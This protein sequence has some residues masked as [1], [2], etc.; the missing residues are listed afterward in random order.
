MENEHGKPKSDSVRRKRITGEIGHGGRPMSATAYDIGAETAILGGMM[1]SPT[2]IAACEDLNPTHFSQPH[3]LIFS[4]IAELHRTGKPILPRTVTTELRERGNL[5]AAGGAV[6]VSGLTYEGTTGA[7]SAAYFVGVVAAKWEH[8]RAREIA[9]HLHHDME[10][11]G[12]LASFDTAMDAVRKLKAQSSGSAPLAASLAARRFNAA[13]PPAQPRPIYTLADATIA[14]PGNIQAV[15]AQAKAGKTAFVG[16]MIAATMQPTGD[17]LGV[18]SSNPTAAAVV[19]FDTEQSPYDHHAVITQALGRAGCEAPDWLRSYRLA[20]VGIADRLGLLRFELAAAREKHGAIHSVFLDGV[21]DLCHDPNDSAEAFALVG[22]L[23]KL[24][25][26]F[27]TTIVCVLHENPGSETGKTRGH[28]GSQ[29][30]RKAE[31][32][33][34]LSKDGEAITTAFTERARHAHV[35]KDHGPRFAW[36]DEAAMHVSVQ[37]TAATKTDAKR[38]RL[39]ELARQIFASVP[40]AVGL[41]WTQVHEQIEQL[42]GIVRDTA[43]KRFDAIRNLKIIRESGGKYRLA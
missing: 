40:D 10:N 33:L 39:E 41:T 30:E 19:H 21:A 20:D 18:S 2:V 37:T 12:T 9:S 26:D 32:N 14:T 4:A 1:M 23:H 34:R 13:N 16:A 11:G 22:E 6:Y 29:L 35:P 24:A 15:S 7:A 5:E 17:T 8:R 43:R 36:N 28:L 42:E 3:D 31:T 27:D 25:I 38:E